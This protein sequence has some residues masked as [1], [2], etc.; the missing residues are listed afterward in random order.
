MDVS[1]LQDVKVLVVDDDQHL[2]ELIKYAFTR[3]GAEVAIALAGDEALRQFR[4]M[5]PDV[6]IL[7]IMLPELDGLEVCQRILRETYVPIILLT[8]LSG[9]EATLRGF[10]CGATD[11]V[12]K[13]F[14][15]RVLLARVQAALKR[16]GPMPEPAGFVGYDD[17]Y[18]RIDLE[19]QQVFVRGRPIQLTSTEYEVLACLLRNAD[20]VVPLEDILREVW[21][22]GYRGSQN[23]VHVYI[24]RLRSKLGTPP[25]EHAYF[26]N[27]HGVGYRFATR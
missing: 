21:G 5:R 7:D 18:L 8:A 24:S 10:G 26:C 27:Q 13:P 12:T 9:E 16:T 14:S 23:Y 22:A 6:V 17:G 25:G 15:I 20:C 3:A 2:C 19:T 4:A 11:Y 1:A